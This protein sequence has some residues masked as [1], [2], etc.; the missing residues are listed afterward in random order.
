MGPSRSIPTRS[1][2]S[3]RRRP[4]RS[5]GPVR[6]FAASGWRA[7]AGLVVA[8]RSWGRMKELMSVG[9]G[10]VYPEDGERAVAE[11][12]G[13]RAGNVIAFGVERHPGREGIV[14]VAETR[15]RDTSTVRAAVA[16][17]VRDAVGLP[18]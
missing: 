17:R 11:V 13:V 5:S 4:A 9:W 15:G 8:L 18:P 1:R 14:V 3:S 16:D 10:N 2:R 7:P 6:P 12:D